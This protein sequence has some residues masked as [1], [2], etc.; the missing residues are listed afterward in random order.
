M[1]FEQALQYMRKGLKVC[2]WDKCFAKYFYIKDGMN[3]YAAHYNEPDEIMNVLS[4]DYILSDNWAVYTPMEETDRKAEK[5]RN[6]DYV[7]KNNSPLYN[8]VVEQLQQ[9]IK[10]LQ[11]EVKDLTEKMNYCNI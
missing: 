7:N 1:T 10:E 11:D 8:C 9:Q 3:I 2:V 4:I 5:I 6:G